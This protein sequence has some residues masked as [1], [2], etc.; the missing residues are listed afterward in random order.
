MAGQAFGVIGLEVMG[1]NI[2]LNIERN[3]FPIAVYNRTY[4]KTEHFLNELARG[5]NAKGGQTIQEFVQL[6]DRPRRILIMVK[7]G[8]PVDAVIAELRS[9]LQDG[10]IVIDGGNSLFTDTERRVKELSGTGI[11]FFGMGVSGGEEGALWGPSLRPGGD[12]DAYQHLEPIL[13]KIAAKSDS[14]P[15]VTYIGSKGAGHFVKMVHNGI[16]YGDMQLISE[17]YD[18]LKNV[19][20]LNNAQL[21]NVFNEWNSGDDLKSFLIE[22]TAKVIDFPDP[23]GT[24]KPLADMILDKAGAKGTGKW[25]TQTALDLGVAI[26][27]ITA[28]VDARS[29]SALKE[30][31]VKAAKV[32]GG[33]SPHAAANSQSFIND[34]R[35]RKSVV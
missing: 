13:T 2:A 16:E 19:A 31:R 20:G 34:V 4:A 18:L 23:D 17:A 33:P 14:G 25:T 35:D 5:K 28:A 26:P 15:C 24:G 11:K 29:I 22:I 10:D 32:L 30:Q 1:R 9:H 27:T 7:A 12:R 21:R 6:L 3:G 8:A